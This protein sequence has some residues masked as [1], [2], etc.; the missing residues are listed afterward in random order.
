M[1][2]L[3]QQRDLV[4]HPALVGAILAA[5]PYVGRHRLVGRKPDG[6]RSQVAGIA[7]AAG[8][9]TPAP[10]FCATDRDDD[11]LPGLD[12]HGCIEHPVL[13]GPGELLA[14]QDQD[15]GGTDVARHQHRNRS[16][17]R[18]LRHHESA[19]GYRLLQ[20]DELRNT[21]EAAEH[22]HE[23]QAAIA[24]RIGQPQLSYQR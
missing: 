16:A 8:A 12:V 21:L 17:L 13:L 20:S 14:V 7:E 9:I 23:G 1:V 24:D 22:G 5:V 19:R 6:R 4:P 10:G 15:A 3:L 11:L 18:D 2:P